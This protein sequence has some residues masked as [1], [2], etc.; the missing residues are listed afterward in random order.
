MEEQLNSA[1]Y[2]TTLRDYLRVIFRQKAV[3]ITAFITVMV[4]VTIGLMLKTPVYESQVKM[5]ISG[6]KQVESSYY[7]DL[8]RDGSFRSDVTLTQSEIVTSNPVLERAIKALGLDQRPLDYEKRFCSPLKAIVI[9]IQLKMINAKREGLK[10]EQKQ[11]YIYRLALEGLKKSI[12]VEPIRDTN[13]FTITARDFSPFGAAIIANVVSRSYIIF[14]LE[15]QLVELQ[16]KYGEKHLA[17]MQL[18]DSIEK[19]AK[20]L[21]GEPL[22]NIEAIGPASVKIMEQSQIPLEPSG[23]PKKLTFLLAIFMALFLGLMLA[24]TFEHLDQTF[25]TPQD[26][27]RT[28]GISLLGAIPKKPKP[29]SY[30]SIA[31]QLCFELRDRN[32]RSLMITAA[33]PK[34]GVTTT[35]ANLAKSVANKCRP[36]VLIID[37]N[38]RRPAIHEF[39]KIANND[40]LV[41][42][43]E[44]RLPLEKAVH[45]TIDN[46]SILT[47]GKADISPATLL[48][49]HSM[50][51]L[52]KAAKEK[53]D[54]V[55]LDCA[56]LREAKDA[57]ALSSY[58]DSI[59]FIVSEG[60]TRRQVAQAAVLSLQGKAIFLGAILNNRTFVIPKAI[61]DR[62]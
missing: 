33:L 24:F 61:Y 36:K 5:L 15:Q 56:N 50:A 28:L 48:E 29:Q 58:V 55:F 6:E 8:I 19:M 32:L 17:V 49:S 9:D 3:I 23:M 47:A 20:G 51:E 14:D 35:I 46:L 11:E 18:R 54:V 53:Y 41:G 16:L 52:V 59:A 13:L 42:V 1:D 26:V 60:R 10:D 39:F 27:E 12:K 38:L 37:A 34:E 62:L 4:T 22:P 25:K 2:E 40:G 7:R 44:G 21:S 43:L 57:I 30:E 31:D 45:N